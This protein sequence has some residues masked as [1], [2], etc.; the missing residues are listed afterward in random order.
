MKT[1]KT[2]RKRAQALA[3]AIVLLLAMLSGCQSADTSGGTSD[4]ESTSTEV[5][6]P[7]AGETAE[8][9]EASSLTR[10]KEPITLTWQTSTSDDYPLD[11]EGLQKVVDKIAEATNVT[12]EWVPVPS[13][14]ANQVYTTTILSGRDQWP[15]LMTKDLG[16]INE[17]GVMGAYVD[18]TPYLKEK[19]PNVYEKLNAYNRWGDMVNLYSKQI[20]GVPRV[21]QNVCSQS[22]MIRKDWLDKCGLEEPTTV[23]EFADCLRVF[24]EQNPGNAPE[25]YNYPFIARGNP[26]SWMSAVFG[27][28]GM[29]S[30]YYTE[31][32]DGTMKLNL[33]MDEF[34]ECMEYWHQLY[35]E[36]LI[37]PEVVTGDGNRWTMYMNNS[38]S[39]ATIDYTVRTQQ[40]TN[41]ERN[42]SDDAIAAGVEPIPDAELIGLTPLTSGDRTN[43][44]ITCYDP[45]NTSLAVGIMSSSTD[46]EIEAAMCL[47]NYIYSEEGSELLSWGIDG[48]SYN[49]LDSDGNPNWVDDLRDNYSIPT[50]AKYGIQPS[51]ARPVTQPETDLA[52]PGLAKE[53]A[54]KNEGHFEK[55]HSTMYLPE[56]ESTEHGDIFAQLSTFYIQAC[57]E[58]LTGVRSL[59]DA[60][61]E[62]FQQDLDNLNADRYM[63]LTEQ[64][65]Q[66]AKDMMEG[67]TLD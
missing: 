66:N 23:E 58:F 27:S 38:Y 8:G 2:L 43:A 9:E 64:G 51:I 21:G 55:L 61:W 62:Q 3:M 39:G 31:F 42:P 30:I 46:E 36:G 63:E 24:K 5:S 10:Y 35:E 32:E 4:T 49:G 44:T 57:S 59:D 16:T 15:N 67:F 1:K 54:L 7:D 45:L 19:M 37:D 52:F 18:L 65:I 40:F 22:W 56:A 17:D 13:T 47:L 53:A 26:Q 34:R 41:A 14:D 50:T 25:G 20:F 33:R 6:S 12:I 48:V 11:S 28:W 60:G 29:N